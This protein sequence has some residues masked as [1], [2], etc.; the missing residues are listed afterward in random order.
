VR[1]EPVGSQ[2]RVTVEHHGWSGIP[3]G[4]AARHGF[5]LDVFQRRLAEHWQDGL[6]AL[7]AR[8]EGSPG[9]PR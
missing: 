2:T 7:R 5:P 6:R 4:H 8:A 9:H 3:R 1:F